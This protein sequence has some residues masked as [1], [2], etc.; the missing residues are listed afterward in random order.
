MRKASRLEETKLEVWDLHY[1]SSILL[2]GV[3]D[4]AF[5]RVITELRNN[6]K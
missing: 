1:F 6:L 4:D 3:G 5:V 2:G